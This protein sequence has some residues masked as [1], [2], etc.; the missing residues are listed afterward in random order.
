MQ[1]WTGNTTRAGGEG[2][3]REGGDGRRGACD[4][5]NAKQ[6]VHLGEETVR[7]GLG[8]VGLSFNRL[9]HGRKGD[10]AEVKRDAVEAAAPAD[11]GGRGK[12]GK[13]QMKTRM[14]MP[15]EERCRLSVWTR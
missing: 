15:S 5:C 11:G 4:A 14:T 9:R 7:G 3:A 8:H 10:R 2:R 6:G 12:I 1:N 13:T